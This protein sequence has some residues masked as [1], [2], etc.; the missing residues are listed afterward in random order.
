MCAD[1]RASCCSRPHIA[2]CTCLGSFRG[3]GCC[4]PPPSTA[5]PWNDTAPSARC[6][7][8]QLAFVASDGCLQ[9][10]PPPGVPGELSRTGRL[11]RLAWALWCGDLGCWSP[12]GLVGA[13]GCGVSLPGSFPLA[14]LGTCLGF[15]PLDG[16]MAHFTLPGLNT[17]LHG[18]YM[19]TRAH[20]RASVLQVG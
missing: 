4:P 14:T 1:G 6:Y 13:C 20:R 16:C 9:T 5:C 19:S 10:S 3:L 17:R 12:Q 2:L 18:C 7:P 15:R 8:L 11:S